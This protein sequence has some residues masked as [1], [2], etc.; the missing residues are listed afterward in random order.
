MGVQTV[1]K[2]FIMRNFFILFATFCGIFLF[3]EINAQ[4][5]N[6]ENGFCIQANQERKEVYLTDINEDQSNRSPRDSRNIPINLSAI[7]VHFKKERNEMEKI[8]FS[9]DEIIQLRKYRIVATIYINSKTKEI[10]AVSFLFRDVNNNDIKIVD[11]RKFAEYREMLKSQ[12]TVQ[13]LEFERE[14]KEHGYIS[15]SFRVFYEK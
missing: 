14:I 15:Q 2:V 12:I 9:E 1:F 3:L 10:G 6:L 5:N 4:D 13:T 7:D 8:I 11:T